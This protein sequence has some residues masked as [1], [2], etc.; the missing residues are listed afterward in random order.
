MGIKPLG[1]LRKSTISSAAWKLSAVLSL[2]GPIYPRVN[3]EVERLWGQRAERVGVWWACMQAK[4][5]QDSEACQE[6]LVFGKELVRFGRIAVLVPTFLIAVGIFSLILNILSLLWAI[7][8]RVH[9]EAG[10][11]TTPSE[12]PI[13]VFPVEPTPG[14]G[15]IQ[16]RHSASF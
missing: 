6:L 4:N 16:R 11:S 14:P 12:N 5:I 2:A 9:R 7:G 13:R 1:G 15:R 10:S 3:K 8:K